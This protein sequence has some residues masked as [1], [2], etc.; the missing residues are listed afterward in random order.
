MEILM[1]SSGIFELEQMEMQQTSHMTHVLLALS[2]HAKKIS[3][4]RSYLLIFWWYWRAQYA[5]EHWTES[6]DNSWQG[7]S[8]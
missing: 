6:V 1:V 2:L 5:Y 3:V 4:S 8:F 7:S